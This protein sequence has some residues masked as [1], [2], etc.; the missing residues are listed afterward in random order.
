MRVP[1]VAAAA[2]LVALTVSPDE[3][4]RRILARDRQKGRTDEDINHRIAHRYFP[5]QQRYRAECDVLG[6]AAAVVDNDDWR[7]PRVVRYMPGQL[8]A[9][10]ERLLEGLPR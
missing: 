9:P 8:P 7:S 4:R 2:A 5:A 6:R 3:A 1:T 10:I